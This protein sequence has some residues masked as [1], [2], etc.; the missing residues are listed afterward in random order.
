MSNRDEYGAIEY[1]ACANYGQGRSF[2]DEIIF[3][4]DY[5]EKSR[6]LKSILAW[7]FGNQRP[8]C[9]SCEMAYADAYCA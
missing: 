4:E 5:A 6:Y 1:Y 2:C 8:E 9:D 3:A 7:Q